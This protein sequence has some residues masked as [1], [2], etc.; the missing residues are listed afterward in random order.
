MHSTSQDITIAGPTGALEACFHLT[1]THNTNPWIMV[2]C[3]P[4]PLY[5]G[6]MDNKVV[7]TLVKAGN[8]LGM[9]ALRFN[10]RRVG[11]SEGKFGNAIGECDDLQAVIHWLE[12]QYLHFR[13][14]LCGFSFG[15]YIAAKVTADRGDVKALLTI[16]PAVLHYDFNGLDTI[17]CP[18]F[19]IQGD[20]DEVVPPQS[21]YDWLEKTS[22][23]VQRI[24]F[25]AAG[26]FFHGR[27]VELR[28][29]VKTCFTPI[30][31]GE[32]RAD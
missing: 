28:E 3:H 22:Q 18:W 2:I 12:T 29:T 20:A 10:Y 4:H 15:A 8:E 6:T 32:S 23:T 11:H 30:V 19:L 17:H 13:L 24:D 5:G 14:V 1:D 21:V 9:H 27:L 16:A 26:H 7:T 25:P 31:Q